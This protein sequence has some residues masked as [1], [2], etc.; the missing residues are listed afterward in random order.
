MF[1]IYLHNNINTIAHAAETL[2]QSDENG[3]WQTAI[4]RNVENKQHEEEDECRLSDQNG[5]LIDQMSQH[6]LC[7]LDT[8]KLQIENKN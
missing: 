7:C 4:A 8:W 3:Q 5:K 1:C 6:N 2:N